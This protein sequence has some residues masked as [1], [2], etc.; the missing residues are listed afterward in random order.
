VAFLF[1]GDMAELTTSKAIL[2]KG[3]LEWFVNITQR[4]W[5]HPSVQASSTA[6]GK[7]VLPLGGTC[8]LCIGN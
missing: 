1:Y 8:F 6:H 4:V 2:I 7:Q 3:G 5:Q